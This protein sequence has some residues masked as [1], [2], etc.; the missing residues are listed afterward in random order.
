MKFYLHQLKEKPGTACQHTLA[1]I[2]LAHL[3]IGLG[4]IPVLIR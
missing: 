1:E 4:A 2:S 3:S